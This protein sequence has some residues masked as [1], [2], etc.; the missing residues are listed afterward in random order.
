MLPITKTAYDGG[1]IVISVGLPITEMAVPIAKAMATNGGHVLDDEESL[2]GN[3]VQPFSSPAHKKAD[4]GNKE[5]SVITL[6]ERLG[7]EDLYS[8]NV[9]R[10]SVGELLG[11]AVLVFMIDTIVISSFQSESKTPNLLM[12]ILIAITITILLLA[13]CPIS[14]GHMNPVISFSAALVGIISLSRAFIYILAQ[15]IGAL[16]GA[17]ALEAVVSKTIT[18]TYSLGGCTLTIVA[19]GPKGTV[20]MGIE[21][22]QALWL[23]IICTFIFLFASIWLAYDH[24][25]AKSLGLVKVF[26]IIGVVLG[27]LVF[28]STSLT[29]KKGYAGAGMNPAR[30]LGPAIIRGG[31]LW[32]GHWVFWVGPAVACM[33]FYI[34][35]KIIPTNHFIHANGYRHDFF[36][37]L[38]ALFQGA[39]LQILQVLFVFA[40]PIPFDVIQ[41]MLPSPPSSS[42]AAEV[43][44]ASLIFGFDVI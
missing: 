9:W 36:N 16:L 30:C 28:I 24:R 44:Y 34:Y 29:G 32:D 41:Y 13:V 20:V 6:G 11:S 14:G 12:S 22:T 4:H 15:C 2:C 26:S 40:L 25:Q 19:P 27:L 5:D 8:L 43:G 42:S 3:R 21:T 37:V 1:L 18:Q 17:L 33:A 10:A 35:T 38:R 7:L 23:E 39:D 31:H